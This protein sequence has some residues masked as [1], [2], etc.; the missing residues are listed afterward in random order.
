[1]ILYIFT[2]YIRIGGK[3]YNILYVIA[4]EKSNYIEPIDS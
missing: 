1:M 4:R 2:V 3:L